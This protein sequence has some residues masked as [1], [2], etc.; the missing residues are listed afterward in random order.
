[1]GN[2]SGKF[3][4]DESV[5]TIR[6]LPKFGIEKPPFTTDFEWPQVTEEGLSFLAKKYAKLMFFK[7]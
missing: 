7:Y 2:R 6:K 4:Y 3:N 1:M 5:K